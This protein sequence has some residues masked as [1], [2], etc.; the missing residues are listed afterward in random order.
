MDMNYK[1]LLLSGFFLI[2][3]ISIFGQHVEFTYDENGNRLTRT[4][5]TLKSATIKFPITDTKALQ[6][7]DNSL[8]SNLGKENQ[9]KQGDGQI[10]PLVY[11]NPTKGLIKIEIQNLT[12]SSTT[13]V[14][15]YDLSGSKLFSEK[16]LENY[17]EIDISKYKDGFYILRIIVD[18]KVFD[19]K[20]IKG[21]AK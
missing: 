1:K 7:T 19:W 21:Q 16:N 3:V 4:L 15:L 13:E 18:D 8:T 14:I 11:P 17:S 12:N 9:Q 5:V 2:H 20:V 6:S 10:T